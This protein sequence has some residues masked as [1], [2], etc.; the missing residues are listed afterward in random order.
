VTEVN[1]SAGD[2]HRQEGR[3][4]DELGD[5]A[6]L[7]PL[8][9]GAW[10]VELHD[11]PGVDDRDAVRHGQRLALVV[12]DVDG[13]HAQLVVQLAQFDLHVFAQLLVQRRKWFVHQHDAWLE[14]HG[15]GQGNPLALPA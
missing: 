14:H 3:L 8:V 13:G 1:L 6:V 5:K 11:A 2:H 4:T 9:D 12:R 10:R 15:T 7:R